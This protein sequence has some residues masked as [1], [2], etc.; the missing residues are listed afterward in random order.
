MTFRLYYLFIFP[1][2]VLILVVFLIFYRS[3]DMY[4]IVQTFVSNNLLN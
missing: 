1:P 3:F 4:S 2:P